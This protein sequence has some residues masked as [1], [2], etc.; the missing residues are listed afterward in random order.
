MRCKDCKRWFFWEDYN[1]RCFDCECKRKRKQ[2]EQR[3]AKELEEERA[4]EVKHIC[5]NCGTINIEGKCRDYDG[6]CKI[7]YADIETG[8][9]TDRFFYVVENTLSEVKSKINT[10]LLPVGYEVIG[11]V[12]AL[13]AYLY[14]QAVIKKEK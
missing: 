3:I 9:Y 5:K 11:R 7:C 1:S 4:R 6:Q 10:Y 13:S 8:K 14:S 2:E 12:V